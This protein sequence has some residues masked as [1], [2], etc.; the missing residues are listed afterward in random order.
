MVRDSFAHSHISE[1][2]EEAGAAAKFAAVN[3]NRKYT[4]LFSMYLFMQSPLRPLA[5][6]TV[7]RWIK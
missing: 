7:K 3:K 1:T 4:D 6:G 5:H 2:S